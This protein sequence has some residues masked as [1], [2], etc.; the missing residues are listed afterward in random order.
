MMLVNLKLK[1]RD[2][3]TKRPLR[4]KRTIVRY[5]DATPE[6]W[7]RG[8]RECSSAGLVSDEGAQIVLGRGAGQ[9]P[10]MNEIWGGGD[11]VVHRQE[12]ECFT[13]RG[14]R[15]TFFVMLQEKSFQK[16]LS[17]KGELARDNGLLARCLITYPPSTQGT[18][19]NW[20]IEEPKWPQLEAFQKRIGEILEMAQWSESASDFKKPVL[21]LSP[22]A[23]ALWVAFANHVESNI[24]PGGLYADVRDAASK[25]AENAGRLAA[26]FHFMEGRKGDIQRDSIDQACQICD[27]YLGEF[28]RIFHKPPPIPEAQ[29]D[30]M[31]LDSWLRNIHNTRGQYMTKRNCARQSGPN[32][33]RNKVRLEA[34]IAAL[35]F[36]GR[37]RMVPCLNSKTWFIEL[38]IH[39]SPYQVLQ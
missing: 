5:R 29:L 14:A 22:D 9:L 31:A 1:M 37:I 21:E 26:L 25:T 32:A 27:W 3:L 2:L 10:I 35:V 28:K 23:K 19:E 30:A 8:L 6:A 18:R 36:A 34:A 7:I 12:S 38:L 15:L 39:S 17:T 20:S 13:V 24:R 33:L 11:V 16:F 4:P